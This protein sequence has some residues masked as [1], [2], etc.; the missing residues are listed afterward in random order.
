MIPRIFHDFMIPVTNHSSLLIHFVFCFPSATRREQRDVGRVGGEL[1]AAKINPQCDCQVCSTRQALAVLTDTKAP[2]KSAHG[3][4]RQGR[5]TEKSCTA[6]P[7]VQD[8]LLFYLSAQHPGE[9]IIHFSLNHPVHPENW[10]ELRVRHLLGVICAD[11]KLTAHT[12]FLC[13]HQAARGAAQLC[14]CPGS[15]AAKGAATWAKAPEGGESF[16]GLEE[17]WHPK[18]CS[19]LF[20]LFLFF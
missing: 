8:S 7:H 16:Q 14:W 13:P 15:T 17:M 9:R 20:S 19:F 2:R 5:Q 3:T 10:I 1:S 11:G 18:S 6:K 12:Q 4:S